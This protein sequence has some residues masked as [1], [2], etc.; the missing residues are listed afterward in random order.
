M[1]N[2]IAIIV[3]TLLYVMVLFLSHMGAAPVWAPKIVFLAVGV[4]IYIESFNKYRIGRLIRDTATSKIGSLPVGLVEVYGKA[5]ALSSVSVIYH[6]LSVREFDSLHLKD[7]IV[8]NNQMDLVASLGI[9]P[10]ESLTVRPFYI[11]DESGAVFVDPLDAEIIANV[12]THKEGNRIYKE[13]EI[14][15]GDYVYCIGTARRTNVVD[16]SDEINKAIKEAKKSKKT[17]ERFDLDNDGKIS[18]EEWNLA[19]KTIE[20]EIINKNLTGDKKDNVISIGKGRENSIFIISDKKE[21][22][23][24]RKYYIQAVLLLL[25]GIAV[26]SCALLSLFVK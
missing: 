6:Y 26:T 5:K 8:N 13:A 23:I 24:V 2:A 17:I 14:K 22:Q 25:L 7:G 4:Y 1:K 20:S 11:E 9:I 10:K 19:R 18:Q 3:F 12:K 21:I 16:I 15:E